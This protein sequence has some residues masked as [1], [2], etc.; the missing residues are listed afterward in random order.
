MSH[1]NHELDTVVVDVDDFQLGD[2]W[3]GSLRECHF[4]LDPTHL[5]AGHTTVLAKQVVVGDGQLQW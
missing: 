3:L 4:P 1:Q 2:A 5:I